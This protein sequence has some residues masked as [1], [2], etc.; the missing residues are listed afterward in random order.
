MFSDILKIKPQ[1][2]NKDLQAMEKQLQ[3]RFTKIAKGF[4]K[5]I[6]SLFKGG[7]LLGLAVG[8]IDKLL[9]PLK[10]VQEA[11]DKTLK[12]SDDLATNAKQFNTTAGRLAKLQ[13]F[14]KA[15]G[16][17]P[18]SLSMLI[19]KF[20]TAVAEAKANPKEPSA[21][22]NFTGQTD[23]AAA[24]FEFI[25]SLQKMNKDQQILV[26]QQVFGEKQILKMADFLNSDFQ[27]VGKYFSRFD[28]AK[29]TR[30][31]NKTADLNDLQDTLAAVR[32]LDDMQK[33]SRLIN[34]GMIRTRDASEKLNLQRE[35]QRIQ[36]Y[37]DLA[38]ISQTSEKIMMM[39]EQGVGLVGKLI[40][41]A[42]PFIDKAT[43]FMQQVLKSPMMRGI[44]SLFG[45][46]D[47]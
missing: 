3:S 21:V 24:F 2:D 15:A 29:L 17:D 43:V 42:L 10:E 8:L 13:A 37:S 18:E 20:Q 34:E 5:G 12:A 22:R 23:T 7:G 31:I 45:G 9:N 28:S 11:I 32:D 46:K 38:A 30:D 40:N 25:Q 26:Q 39:V 4:G 35:N 6:G 19:T 44:K 41:V 36:S 1:I 47:E 14:G 16:L 33:K 27:A